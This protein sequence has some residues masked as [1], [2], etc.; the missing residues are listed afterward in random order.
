MYVYIFNIYIIYRLHNFDWIPFSLP[1]FHLA[2]DIVQVA[3]NGTVLWPFARWDF[4]PESCL[5]RDKRRE[6]LKT[7][8]SSEIFVVFL[9][10]PKR[11][12]MV[13]WPS[14]P[15]L[16]P[17]LQKN[18]GWMSRMSSCHSSEVAVP[19]NVPTISN[20]LRKTARLHQISDQS[21]QVFF[22]ILIHFGNDMVEIMTKCQY[23]QQHI[24]YKKSTL[25]DHCWTTTALL[26][27]F[28]SETIPS[29]I[30]YIKSSNLGLT[31]R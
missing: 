13:M 2:F 16:C 10:K 3:S 4:G 5:P 15:L 6:D 11:N 19:W 20:N 22:H 7:Q 28:L 23:W 30:K 12:A 27:C 25:C 29:L 14:L 17:P 8:K 21:K 18:N 9:W 26:L 31:F 24:I 1:S